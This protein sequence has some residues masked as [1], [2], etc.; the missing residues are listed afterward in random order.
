MFSLQ[1]WVPAQIVTRE[2][3]EPGGSQYSSGLWQGDGNGSSSQ[4][5]SAE[6]PV[7]EIGKYV[8]HSLLGVEG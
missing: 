5:L 1:S 6:R 7:Y 4:H 3:M 2:M 8:E